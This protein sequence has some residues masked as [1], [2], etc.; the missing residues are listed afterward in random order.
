LVSKD[1]IRLPG[2]DNTALRDNYKDDSYLSELFSTAELKWIVLPY[3][4]RVRRRRLLA[5][6]RGRIFFARWHARF[7]TRGS[8]LLT[9]A[10]VAGARGP[11]GRGQHVAR[12]A[13]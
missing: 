5:A 12:T 1:V 9:S 2:L 13:P 6:A 8:E 7:G 10:C 3:G 4:R 11:R